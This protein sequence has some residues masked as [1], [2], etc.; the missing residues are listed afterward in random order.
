MEQNL[1]EETHMIKTS[2]KLVFIF[3][4]FLLLFVLSRASVQAGAE[5]VSETW[6]GKV[7]GMVEGDVNIIIK[8]PPGEDNTFPFK[9]RVFITAK[10]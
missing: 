1:S 10:K 6:V 9:G 7:T 3:S 5:V 4:F 2:T 8:R